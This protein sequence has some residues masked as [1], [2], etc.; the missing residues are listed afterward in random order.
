MEG[1]T[2]AGEKPE[3]TSADGAKT[4]KLFD[5]VKVKIVVEQEGQSRQEHLVLSIV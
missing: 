1:W 3:I 4:L 2:K 5:N